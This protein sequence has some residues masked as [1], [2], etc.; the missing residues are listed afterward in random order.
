MFV[1]SRAKQWR[2]KSSSGLMKKINNIKSKLEI[3]PKRH[4]GRQNANKQSMSHG[5]GK[6]GKSAVN[7]KVPQEF[8]PP[9]KMGIEGT[10]LLNK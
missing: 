5:E 1:G 4:R 8:W 10:L 3:P 2:T 6:N 9:N 7:V